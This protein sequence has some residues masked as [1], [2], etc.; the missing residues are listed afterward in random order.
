MKNKD[1]FALLY[2]KC[3]FYSSTVAV[4]HPEDVAVLRIRHVYVI[5]KLIRSV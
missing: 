2:L 1:F 5:H 4:R 3:R